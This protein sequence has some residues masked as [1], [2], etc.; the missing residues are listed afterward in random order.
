M[1]ARLAAVAAWTEIGALLVLHPRMREG[2]YLRK[3]SF[4]TFQQ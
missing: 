1:H 3:Q 4:R 2:N